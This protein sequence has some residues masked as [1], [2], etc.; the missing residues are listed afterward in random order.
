[1]KNFKNYFKFYILVFILFLILIPFL[2]FAQEGELITQKDTILKAKVIEIINE[3]KIFLPVTE[4]EGTFQNIKAEIL[5]K[6]R[7]GEIVKVENDYLSLKVGEKFY[8]NEKIQDDVVFYS[9]HDKYRLPAIIFFTILFFVLVIIFG[10]IQGVRGVVSLIGSIILI[11]LVLIPGILKGYSPVLITIVISSIIIVLGSY[12]THGFNKTTSSAVVGMLVTFLIT[13]FL[14]KFA[15]EISNLTGFESEEAVYLD[16]NTKGTIDFVGLLFGGIV[17]GLLGVLYDVAIEQ[18]ISVEELR[19]ASNHKM[20]RKKIFK[21]VMRIGREHTGALVNTLAIAY[22]G[23]SLPLLLLFYSSSTVSF[24]EAI[25]REIFAT[26]IIRTIV[27]SIGL[28]LAVPITSIISVLMLV[29]KKE[30]DE[31]FDLPDFHNHAH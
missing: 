25:N 23:A 8:L 18:A 14:A 27:G 26:E 9:V 22:V 13:G 16:W 21:R 1:M 7:K 19:S 29:P 20:T 6:E 5:S 30:G 4:K 31:K 28:V 10:G 2:S 12:I 17:I 24:S 15:V 11:I 3:E